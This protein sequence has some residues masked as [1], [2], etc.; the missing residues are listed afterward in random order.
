MLTVYVSRALTAKA[1]KNELGYNRFGV[2][3]GTAVEARATRRHT[4]KRV[5]LGCVRQWAPLST[6]FVFFLARPASRLS[7]REL[8]AELARAHERI[9]YLNLKP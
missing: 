7:R 3:V 2:V 9:V 5:L 1:K 6:D 4:L 8:H